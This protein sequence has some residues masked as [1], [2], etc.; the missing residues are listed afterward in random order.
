LGGP[1]RGSS[2]SKA[3]NVQLELQIGL[4]SQQKKKIWVSFFFW[5]G[6][7]GGGGKRFFF[8]LP[9]GGG[10]GG[11]GGG[12]GFLL[13]EFFSKIQES[14]VADWFRRGFDRRTEAA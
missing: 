7:P 3:K 4:G 11:V 10:G 12:G 1:R 8:F 5:G 6:G 2:T 14:E 9:G 13:D